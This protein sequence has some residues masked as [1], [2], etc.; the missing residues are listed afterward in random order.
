MNAFT[1]M[2]PAGRGLALP[3]GLYEE[4]DGSFRWKPSRTWR[5]KGHAGRRVTRGDGSIVYDRA[6]AIDIF[7]RFKAELKR[8]TAPT[9]TTMV[10]E[11]TVDALIKMYKTN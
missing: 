7:T 3:A 10:S 4:A 5:R 11:R 8:G 9:T 2:R 1:G 6:E